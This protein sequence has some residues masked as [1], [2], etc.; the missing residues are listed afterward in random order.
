[1]DRVII[2]IEIEQD[3]THER[4]VIKI[5]RAVMVSNTQG[6]R[7]N[8]GRRRTLKIMNWK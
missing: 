3:V 8:L 1:M 2:L 7:E 4:I 6:Q 5:F